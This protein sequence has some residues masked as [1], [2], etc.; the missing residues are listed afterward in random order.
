M[1]GQRQGEH[2]SSWEGLG[3]GQ[4]ARRGICSTATYLRNAV[5]L[6]VD[7]HLTSTLLMT[8]E[9]VLADPPWDLLA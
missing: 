9:W 6:T 5:T 8:M 7:S 1:K 3:E 4:E 2:G